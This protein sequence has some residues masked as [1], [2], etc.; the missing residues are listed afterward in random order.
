MSA[1]TTSFQFND[2][3]GSHREKMTE[4]QRGEQDQIVSKYE[5]RKQAY[6]AQHQRDAIDK[7]AEQEERIT[8][9]NEAKMQA[10]R[11]QWAPTP[12]MPTRDEIRADA[13]KTVAAA[14]QRAQD[15]AEAA[16]RINKGDHTRESL[17][18]PSVPSSYE[19]RKEAYLKQFEEQRKQ[20]QKQGISQE[21]ERE[22]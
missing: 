12:K 3:S 11:P 16:H 8:K 13:Q 4:T 9:T 6:E 19:Q 7:V 15:E 17:N 22:R 10:P 1:D 5:A 20:E 14:H 21:H 18:L 2:A